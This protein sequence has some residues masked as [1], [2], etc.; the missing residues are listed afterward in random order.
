M[1]IDKLIRYTAVAVLLLCVVGIAQA[2]VW[3]TNNVTGTPPTLCANDQPISNCAPTGYRVEHARAISG[4]FVAVGTAPTPNFAHTNV[5]AGLNC[6]RFV[7]L[8]ANGES[9]PSLVEAGSCW[10]NVAPIPPSPP[11]PVTNVRVTVAVVAN[12]LR[13]PVFSVVSSGGGLTVGAYYGSVPVGT[14]CGDYLFT[15]RKAKFH[16]V[17]PDSTHLWGRTELRGL[18]APCA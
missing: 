2:Q 11:G 17:V 3:N 15:Y 4:P 6:Y 14:P 8:S 7:V 9:A 16:R 18:V 10:T 1:N 5:A 12:D 13:T